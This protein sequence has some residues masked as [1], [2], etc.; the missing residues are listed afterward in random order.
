MAARQT[1]LRRIK[2][3]RHGTV[4]TPADFADL[5]TPYAVGMA[6]ARLVK[7]GQLRRVGRGLYDMPRRDFRLGPLA[8]NLDAIARALA[9]RYGIKLQPTG[10]YAANLL[11]LSDQVPM[12]VAYLTDGTPRTVRVG[13]VHIL[14]RHTT[15]RTMAT[16]GR[17]SGLVIQA[18]RWIAR[19]NVTADLLHPLRRKLDRKAKRQL[20]TD[21]HLA[22]VWVGN[23]MRWLA[24]DESK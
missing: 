21:A 16:A 2:K 7:A 17:V 12:R 5:G 18:L 20:N 11:G 22:P 10:A 8:P 19:A 13:N 15:P 4:F 23:W 3:A 14:L 1:I 24:K 9:S 6:L